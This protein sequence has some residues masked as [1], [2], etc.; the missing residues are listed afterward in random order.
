MGN[1]VKNANLPKGTFIVTFTWRSGGMFYKKV[2]VPARSDMTVIEL[3][4]AFL[5]IHGSSSL[6]DLDDLSYNDNTLDDEETL[7]SYEIKKGALLHFSIFKRGVMD[8]GVFDVNHEGK[9]GSKVLKEGGSDIDIGK[10]I[11][12]LKGSAG[13]K[14]EYYPP[15][16][17]P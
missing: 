9:I 5:Q 2:D 13:A 4:R 7:E 8:I 3:K 1:I 6:D 14:F 10:V 15:G 11:D 17:L 16:L 12:E